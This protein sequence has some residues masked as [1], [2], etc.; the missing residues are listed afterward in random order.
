MLIHRDLRNLGPLHWAASF[1]GVLAI[2]LR[3]QA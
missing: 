2:V 3:Y 1:D